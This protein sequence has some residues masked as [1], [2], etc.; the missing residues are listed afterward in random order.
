MRVYAVWVWCGL[1]W[2]CAEQIC[3][4]LLCAVENAVAEFPGISSVEAFNCVPRRFWLSRNMIIFVSIICRCCREVS[5]MKYDLYLRKS[6][7]GGVGKA[8]TTGLRS[9]DPEH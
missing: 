6:S 5:S 2:E 3:V 9:R 1:W 4:I 8:N 7:P